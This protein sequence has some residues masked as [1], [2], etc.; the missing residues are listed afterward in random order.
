MRFF[1]QIIACRRRMAQRFKETPLAKLFVLS[2]Q[3]GMLK[4]R[5]VAGR[6]RRCI[7]FEMML[8]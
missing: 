4:M 3:F 2:D 1:L 7:R 5:S 6:M 8:S